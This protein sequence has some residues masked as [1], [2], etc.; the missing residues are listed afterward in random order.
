VAAV[1]SEQAQAMLEVEELVVVA[2]VAKWLL[3]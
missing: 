2:L 3:E 1:A